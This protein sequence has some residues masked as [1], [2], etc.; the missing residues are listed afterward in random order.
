ML[1]SMSKPSS[2][3]SSNWLDRLRSSKGFP[4]SPDLDLD[5]FLLSSNPNPNPTKPPKH[6]DH[7]LAATFMSDVLSDLFVINN[8]PPKPPQKTSRKQPNPRNHVV[9]PPPTGAVSPSSADNSV[10]EAGRNRAAAAGATVKLKKKKKKRES[11][12]SAESDLSGF[13][14]TE[15]TVIDTSSGSPGWKSEKVVFRKGL[16]WK[17]REK[18]VR[19]FVRK[20]RKVGS[21]ERVASEKEKSVTAPAMAAEEEEVADKDTDDLILRPRRRPKFLRSPHVL[22]TKHPSG[23]RLEAIGTSK[24]SGS[25]DPRGALKAN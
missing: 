22:A 16:V 15:V 7:H 14:R 18:K 3:S 1:S 9:P 25:S 20:K 11:H 13:S 8:R 12:G 5:H 19:S 10:A 2:S 24:K 21:M 4:L 23:F 17:V 6:G